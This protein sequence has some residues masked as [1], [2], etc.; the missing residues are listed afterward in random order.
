MRA[1]IRR[2]GVSTLL[3]GLALWVNPGGAL[4]QGADP[5][6][7]TWKM[8]PAKSRYD[9]GPA[10][11]SVTVTFAPAGD[12]VKVT[13]DEVDADGKARQTEY[14]VKYD[15]K[16][17]PIKGAANADTV[18][19]KRIDANTT[20]RTD[21][22]GGKVVATFQRKVSTDGKTLTVTLTG[23]NAQGK[24]VNNAVVLDRQ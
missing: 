17:Y 19:V 16:D 21:K 11:R 13:A 4:A 24:P 22:K 15:G 8:N 2:L 5:L 18:A 1:G 3:A 12:G 9:P 10:P 20:E 6:L 23:T 14:T 7:G